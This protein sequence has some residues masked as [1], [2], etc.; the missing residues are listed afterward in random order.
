MMCWRTLPCSELTTVSS[1]S[2]ASSVDGRE[3]PSEPERFLWPST[4]VG[5]VVGWMSRWR[6]WLG[7]SEELRLLQEGRV[8]K[9]NV[10]V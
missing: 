8:I 3:L 9:L 10:E 6:R 4:I 2:A 5:E 1:S 7:G